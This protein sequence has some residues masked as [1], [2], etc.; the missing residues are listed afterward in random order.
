ME[1]GRSV[2]ATVGLDPAGSGTA[3][4][5]VVVLRDVA[6]PPGPTSGA[7]GGD[8]TAPPDGA[9]EPVW[10]VVAAYEVSAPTGP[11][12]VLPGG[13][14]AALPDGTL[15]PGVS[16]ALSDG[17]LTARQRQVAALVAT[18]LTN[19]QIAHRLA[20]TERTVR[21]HLAD[22]CGRTGAVNRAALAAWW[23]GRSAT[24]G[25]VGRSATL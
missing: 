14:R 20:L 9:R 15:P 8:G 5:L 16:A 23:G 1:Q 24:W 6:A 3:S 10:C 2:T 18:G 21:K 7:A 19:A 22:A 25:A 11:V 12:L 13:T 17:V 4:L